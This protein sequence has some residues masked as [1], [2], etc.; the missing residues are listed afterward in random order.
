MTCRHL[1][2]SLTCH[3][4]I[5]IIVKEE[6]SADD[7]VEQPSAGDAISTDPS[8]QESADRPSKRWP[9]ESV[10]AYSSLFF[11]LCMETPEFLKRLLLHYA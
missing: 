8:T 6:R 9:L 5:L 10:Q 11:A 1:S 4:S 3:I 7:S 2:S